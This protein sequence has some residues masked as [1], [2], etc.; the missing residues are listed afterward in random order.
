[1]PKKRG[2]LINVAA[3]VNGLAFAPKRPS[4]DS[5]PCTEYLAVGCYQGAEDETREIAVQTA[6]KNCI[7]LWRLRLSSEEP[8]ENTLDLCILH[9]YGPVLGIEWCPYGT[10]EETTDDEKQLP[11]LGILSAVFGDGSVRVM[12]IPHPKALRRQLEIQDPNETIYSKPFAP[13]CFLFLTYAHTAFPSA[14][15]SGPLCDRTLCLIAYH[16]CLGRHSAACHRI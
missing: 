10:Y 8:L 11:K 16:T 7:Q 2:L 9:E 15:R 13:F 3:A 1:M 6:Y 5:E 4:A 12:I 14:T